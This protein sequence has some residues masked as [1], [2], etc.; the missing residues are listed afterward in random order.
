MTPK[1]DQW[2]GPP[3]VLKK[4]N[5]KQN[6]NDNAP[7]A[8]LLTLAGRFNF[9]SLMFSFN[10]FTNKS[11]SF[12]MILLCR[13]VF[14]TSSN[15][16]TRLFT[17]FPTRPRP[18]TNT[19]SAILTMS[20]ACS[21]RTLLTSN[22]DYMALLWP[23]WWTLSHPSVGT[24]QTCERRCKHKHKQSFSILPLLFF[25]WL[26]IHTT[27]HPL[28]FDSYSYS[29][30]ETAMLWTC[31]SVVGGFLGSTCLNLH[32]LVYYG[33]KGGQNLENFT[34]VIR[35]TVKPLHF[36]CSLISFRGQWTELQ[37]E[38]QFATDLRHRCFRYIHSKDADLYLHVSVRK[39]LNKA[40]L[41]TR[42]LRQTFP[43]RLGQILQHPSLPHLQDPW[44]HGR[45]LRTKLPAIR[46]RHPQEVTGY[47]SYPPYPPGYTSSVY[48]HYNFT[49][50]V[51]PPNS[52]AYR[53]LT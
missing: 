18:I 48:K 15:V 9:M 27:F 45:V 7:N 43:S 46:Y 44:Q 24:S 35:Q 16:R 1:N 47:P 17:A 6:D 11:I 5:R 10:V 26:C 23:K 50:R 30:R 51:S 52:D 38:I 14:F 4:R 19:A 42:R 37:L 22:K 2:L 20:W 13:L 40:K 8:R 33:A 36:M 29:S 41:V 53:S 31:R 21:H 25:V 32:F 34:D 49:Y 12:E 39:R 28:W 3:S